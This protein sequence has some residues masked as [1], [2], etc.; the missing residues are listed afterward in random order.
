LRD[1]AIMVADH[2][3]PRCKGAEVRKRKAAHS[4]LHLGGGVEHGQSPVS[5]QEGPVPAHP[6]G[7]CLQETEV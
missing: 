3:R 6:R 5:G 1:L 7:R 4:G 2:P